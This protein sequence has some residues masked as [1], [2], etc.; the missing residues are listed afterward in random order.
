M[1]V[2]QRVSLCVWIHLDTMVCGM[3]APCKTC[4]TMFLPSSQWDSLGIKTNGRDLQQTG[5]TVHLVG[6]LNPSEKY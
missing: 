5:N 2:Y 1:L 6:G 3:M 4:I